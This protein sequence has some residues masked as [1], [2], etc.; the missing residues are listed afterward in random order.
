MPKVSVIIPVYNVENYLRQ[1]LDSVINQT[2]KDI[3]IILVDDGSTDS[4]LSVCNEY[5]Q[6]DNR[7]T[8]LTQQ[9]KGAGAAR[10]MGL[11]RATGEY[12]SI[13]DSDDYFELNMLEKMYNAACRHNNDITICHSIEFDNT[14][15]E[16]LHSKWI[17]RDELL[18]EKEVFNHKDIPLYIIGFCQGWAWDKL[19]KTSFVKDNRLKFQDLECTNDMYF[20]M[21]SLV[22]AERI[23]VIKDVLV[24][25]RQNVVSSV[26]GNRDK[27]PFCFIDAI[28]KLKQTLEEKDLYEEIKQSFINWNVEFCFWHLDTLK[29]LKNKKQL[30]QRLQSEVFK[31]LDVYS[32]KKDFFFNPKIYERIHKKKIYKTQHWYQYIFSVRNL[33]NYKVMTILGVKIKFK[34]RKNKLPAIVKNIF[35]INKSRNNKHNI[36]KILGIKLK[37]KRRVH[38][39]DKL[40]Y[41]NYVLNHQLDKSCFIP[42]TEDKHQFKKD[43]VKLIAFYL[44]QFHDFEE[45]V[46]WFGPGFSEWS[47]TSKAVPQY[48]GH[49][50]P[51][52]PIDVGYYNLDNTDVIKKQ[53]ELAKQ[54]GIY[55]FSFYYYWYSGKKL[56][57]KPLEKFL[58]DKSLDIP[59]FLFWANHDWSKLWDNGA[60]CEVLY[61]QT[62][63]KDDA[64]KFMNDVLPYMKDERYI[65]IDNKPLMVLYDLNKYPY[66]VYLEF[67][68][69][70]RKIAKENGF[71][72]LYIISPVGGTDNI[73]ELKDKID[74]YEINSLFEFWPYGFKEYKNL[75]IEDTFKKIVNPYFKGTIYNVKKFIEDKKFLYNADFNVF[76]GC[77]PNWDNTPRKCYNGAQICENTPYYY[78]KWL[79][80]LIEWTKC[81]KPNNEQYIFINAWNEWAEGAHLEPDQKYGYAYLQAT[82]EA[83][84][85]TSDMQALIKP[86]K[87]LILKKESFMQKIFSIKNTFD[88]KRK[89]VT[90]LGIKLKIKRKK[91]DILLHINK[92]KLTKEIQKNTGYG[93]SDH[94]RN[95]QL[96]VSLTSFPQRMNDIHYCLHSL[97]CQTL[98]PNK[99]ILWL[100]EEQFPNKEKDLPKKVLELKQRGLSIEWCKDTKSYKKLIPA[101]KKYPDDI[102][103]TADDDIYYPNDWLEKLYNAYLNDN[104]SIHSH[105][106]H[107]ITF[108]FNKNINPYTNWEQCIKYQDKSFLNFSTGAGGILYPPHSLYKDIL[109]ETL[110]LKL[111]P[112][113]DDI[114]FWAMAV[115]NGTQ[116]HIVQN[117]MEELV[118]INPERELGL[119]NE[120]TLFK[121]NGINGENDIQIRNLIKYYP[122]IMEKLLNE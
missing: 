110:F 83:L 84:E 65:K 64:I 105:R 69:E 14:T 86:H 119:T 88:R 97:L 78:K 107:K 52:I 40:A 49:Y 25:H 103:V 75:L 59:F 55:G 118:Y 92:N 27:N 91:A 21:L 34:K 61:K 16:K 76:K 38:K 23:S 32:L 39:K 46:K 10:N 104:K 100:A 116:T 13:L 71:D 3:E 12:L 95:P 4:S 77:F 7:I 70:I 74:K 44:P 79:S 98:K 28:Y 72:D 87:K 121:K 114:W 63:Y 35:S 50:Q 5:A 62:L 106:V 85:H 37:V 45:N 68:R 93:L 51:H 20:V 94:D 54:Y 41:V 102:I 89:I 18:P 82:K 26:S 33:Q 108:D 36:V 109:D 47:N 117:N 90:I 31:N 42:K 15:G 81:N 113:A 30:A 120:I 99:L 6:K 2:L 17:I 56:M 24:N 29:L 53:I 73:Q 66:D 60:N 8:V 22:L 48:D 43:D 111:A 57:E 58:A 80:S 9:N 115:L 67:N 1:C 19:Y 96:I 122:Q 11:E 101:L 112:N